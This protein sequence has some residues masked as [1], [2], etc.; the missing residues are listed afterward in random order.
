MTTAAERA[1]ELLIDRVTEGLD[2]RTERRLDGLLWECPDLDPESFELAAAAIELAYT[3]A[4]EPLPA[5][6]R[7]R[8][9]RQAADFYRQ[10]QAVPEAGPAGVVA[11][12]SR[13]EETASN[14]SRWLGWLA[15]AAAMVLAVV[16]WWPE[17]EKRLDPVA[18]RS[19]L[20][21]RA[22][23]LLELE[24]TATE[25]P[26]ATGASGDV[27]WSTALQRG[28]MRFNS[29]Q[30]NDPTVEQYQLWIFDA[31]QDERYP[32]DGGVFDVSA[33]GEVV[34]EITAKLEVTRPTLFAVTIEKPGGVVV[35]SR[36]RLPLLARVG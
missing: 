31:E 7:D 14:R 30:V 13:Q 1:Q 16:G 12:P 8:V 29:L 36:E 35:S 28:Y 6:L 2:P 22:A 18:A 32:V 23:D 4:K 33:A 34:V 9:A 20:I 17:E 19:E 27:V 26:A 3:S 5:A 25:D 21:A 15:A 11:F 24:W 10:E